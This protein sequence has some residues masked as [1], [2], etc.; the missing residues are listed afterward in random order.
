MTRKYIFFFISAIAILILTQGFNSH[1]NYENSLME[2]T[3][4]QKIDEADIRQK[5]DSHIKS[6]RAKDLEGTLS[7]YAPDIVSFD[8]VPPLHYE[9]MDAK[10]KA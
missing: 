6:I 8:L 2:M 10:R 4:Q 1:N 5:I 3:K 9:G 7:I